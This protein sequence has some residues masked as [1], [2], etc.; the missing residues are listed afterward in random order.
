MSILKEL[1]KEYIMILHGRNKGFVYE[2]DI[3]RLKLFQL[4]ER[5]DRIICDVKTEQDKILL[6]NDWTHH[7]VYYSYWGTPFHGM[8][9]DAS[10][11]LG[12][13]RNKMMRGFC[14]TYA[15]TFIQACISNNIHARSIHIETNDGHGHEIAD[16]W[17]NERKKWVVVDPSFNIIYLKFPQP[18]TNYSLPPF[19]EIEPLD[20]V[21]LH[22]Y[23]LTGEYD[24]F[25]IFHPMFSYTGVERFKE[26][27]IPYF[28]NF[29]IR[30]RNNFITNNYHTN[31][32]DCEENIL[33]WI[34]GKSKEDEFLWKES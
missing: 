6:L 2:D 8:P 22:G 9:I 16:A 18:S 15:F 33:K 20:I 26:R 5:L 31:R 30:M 14:G 17:D 23:S 19:Y 24:K 21:E 1:K 12:L 3:I 10:T 13:I 32:D 27:I 7:Q 29:F 4:Q 34:D 25:T 28:R 11:R